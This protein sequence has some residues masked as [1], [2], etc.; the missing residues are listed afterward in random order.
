M[1]EIYLGTVAIEPNRWTAITG[2]RRPTIRAS[3]WLDAISA[4]GFDG[5]ELWEPHF[6][7]ADPEEVTAIMD[8]PLPIAVYNSY[9]GFD[10]PS[11]DDRD[12]AADCIRRSGASKVKWNSGP[13]RDD[14]SIEAYGE[15]LARWAAQL[16]DT[17]LTCECHDGSA[18]DDP[19]VAAKVLAAGGPADHIQAIVHTKDSDDRLRSKFDAYGD[20]IGHVH[21]NYDNLPG[22]PHLSELRD[23]YHSTLSLLAELGFRGTWTIEFVHGIG[24][25]D[26]HPEAL[27]EEAA[28]D[29]SLTREILG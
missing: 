17:R 21:I 5:V 10:E 12:A 2:D 8:H 25:E 28:A 18:M 27:I 7:N 4:A 23:R 9:V 19:L 3:E 16:P 11:D 14:A 20:R 29:L 6:V 13:Q 15:R 22:P 24:T 26:D 1:A